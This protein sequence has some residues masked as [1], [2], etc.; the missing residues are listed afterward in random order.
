MA[1]TVRIIRYFILLILLGYLIYMTYAYM[2][3]GMD[4]LLIVGSLMMAASAV[5][6]SVLLAPLKSELNKRRK[7]KDL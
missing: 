5:V 6:M 4:P 1:K 2:K 3:G 7:K